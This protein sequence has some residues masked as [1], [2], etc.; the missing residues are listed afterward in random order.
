MI[1]E[2]TKIRIL[3]PRSIKTHAPQYFKAMDKINKI[4]FLFHNICHNAGLNSCNKFEKSVIKWRLVNLR[5]LFCSFLKYELGKNTD[6]A[7]FLSHNIKFNVIKC[8]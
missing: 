1:T 8:K 2:L 7:L 3:Y 6:L 4:K 5:C